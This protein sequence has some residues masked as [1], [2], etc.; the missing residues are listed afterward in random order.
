MDY[1]LSIHRRLSEVNT[2]DAVSR[3]KARAAARRAL[4]YLL[5]PE[6]RAALAESKRR[7]D[8]FAESLKKT[9]PTKETWDWTPTI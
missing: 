4:K 1:R 6:G 9:R 8:E 5:S 7:C 3:K 2:M